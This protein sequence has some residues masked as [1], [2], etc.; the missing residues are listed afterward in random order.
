MGKL[1][2]DQV[3][4]EDRA[5]MCQDCDDCRHFIGTDTKNGTCAQVQG[6]ISPE[7][8]CKLYNGKEPF[9]ILGQKRREDEP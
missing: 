3:G 8:W 9:E 4:Y 7:G 2:K 5:T 6:T 1:T